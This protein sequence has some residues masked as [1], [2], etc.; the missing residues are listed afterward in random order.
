V[1]RLK[2]WATTAQFLFFNCNNYIHIFECKFTKI[3]EFL[4][5]VVNMRL[6]LASKFCLSFEETHPGQ[7]W[8]SLYQHPLVASS[9]SAV[10]ETQI[11]LANSCCLV[12]WCYF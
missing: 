12:I 11:E 10:H 1:L 6:K 9:S 3:T 7:A 2:A 8:L 4:F 5:T